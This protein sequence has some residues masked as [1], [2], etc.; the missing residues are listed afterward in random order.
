LSLH[1]ESEGA[2][3]PVLFLHGVSGAGA[4]YRWLSLEGR[5]AVRLT[6]RGH[7][8]SARRPGTYQLP[9]Y[10]EDALTVLEEIGPAAIVGHSLGGV[11]AWTV[12]QQR[13]DLVTKLFLEDPPLFGGEPQYHR[14]NP[15]VLAF[16]EQQAQVR[17]WQARGATEAEIAAE[18][19]FTEIQA[20]DAVA[21]RAYAL[22]HLDPEVLGPILDG[23]ALAP[24]DTTAPV[25]VPVFILAADEAQGAALWGEHEQRLASTHPDV[26][27]ARIPGAPHT[28]HDTAALREEYVARL[29]AFL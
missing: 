13:P 4:T 18:L 1:I 3:E 29:L 24:I 8:A 25:A 7:G 15:S 28:I 20:P 2:G 10:V 22:R 21:A 26:R 12:A 27:V 6:F 14:A 16:T 5:R 23:S 11:T 9:G 19:D 17:A